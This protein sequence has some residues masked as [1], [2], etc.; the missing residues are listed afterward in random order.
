MT[1]QLLVGEWCLCQLYSV[2]DQLYLLPGWVADLL[3]EV[4]VINGTMSLSVSE[5]E[6]YF[7][8]KIFASTL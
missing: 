5:T 6:S 4:C 7:I 1:L 8:E 2:P 3:E